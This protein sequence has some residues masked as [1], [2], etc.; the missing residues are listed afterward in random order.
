MS[1]YIINTDDVKPPSSLRRGNQVGE[2]ENEGEKEPPLV[3]YKSEAISSMDAARLPVSSGC[4][5]LLPLGNIRLAPADSLSSW[6]S[7]GSFTSSSQQQR[8]DSISS[9][10]PISKR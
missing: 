2:A 5:W 7:F 6:F 10:V 4:G 1:V 3:L 9:R 8:V